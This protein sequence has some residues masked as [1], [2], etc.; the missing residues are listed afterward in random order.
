[1]NIYG[2]MHVGFDPEYCSEDRN[3]GWGWIAAWYFIIFIIIGVMVLVSLFVGVIITSMELLQISIKDESEMLKKVWTK[4]KEYKISNAMV[5]SML[6][7][8]DMVDLCA[9]GRLTVSANTTHTYL[10]NP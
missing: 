4:Q 5:A 2:C 8:F 10:R 9:N 3:N 1:M 6:E 7:I